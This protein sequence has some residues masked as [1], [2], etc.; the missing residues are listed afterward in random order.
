MELVT[1]YPMPR[2]LTEQLLRRF[3]QGRSDVVYYADEIV[4]SGDYAIRQIGGGVACHSLV[5]NLN[6]RGYTSAPEILKAY[7]CVVPSV[8]HTQPNA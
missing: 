5:D 8:R 4:V 3:G 6:D 7:W 1:K 2:D